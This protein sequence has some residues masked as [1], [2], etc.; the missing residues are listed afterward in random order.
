MMK[1]L[2]FLILLFAGSIL[3]T[4]ATHL[5][6]G[7]I[8]P[9]NTDDLIRVQPHTQIKASQQQDR[10]RQERTHGRQLRNDCNGKQP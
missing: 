9:V 5:M 10:P 1:K 2:T 6:G 8:T 3:P 7:E 4:H